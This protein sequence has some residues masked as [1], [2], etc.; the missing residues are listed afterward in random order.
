LARLLST[1]LLIALLAATAAAFAFT[2]GAKLEPSP[3]F[4]TRVPEVF[5]P[6]CN[7]ETSVATLSF[8]LRKADRVT[9]WVERDGE[10]V[11]T[12]VSG[13]SYPAGVVPVV[14]DGVSGQGLT[15]PPGVYRPVVRLERAHRTIVLPDSIE[16][17]TKPPAVHV[18]HRIYSHLSPDGD[19][20]K[21]VFSVP[22]RLSESGRAVLL[23]DGREA[24]V[25]DGRSRR[26]VVRWDGTIGGRVAAPGNHVLRISAEDVAGN[27]AQPFPFA[28]VQIR[29]VRLGRDR[30]LA[31]PG[32]Y[33]AIL[34][35]S[36]AEQVSWLFNRR[37]GVA[38]PGTLRFKAP[39]KP[40]VYR[41]YV[42]AAGHSDKAIVVVA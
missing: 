40:G 20:R 28:V 5:S 32:G 13:R 7:C 41:L 38:R 27:R 26:G 33:F 2:E 3:I 39:K 30:V 21:D 19:G 35:L 37:R 18:R 31:K 11:S 9:V 15:L 25:T 24:V 6:A 29:Y 23:V 22:Y 17:D 16:L 8:R 36:D 1:V 4:A 10:R 14:F 34:A 12:L 42:T